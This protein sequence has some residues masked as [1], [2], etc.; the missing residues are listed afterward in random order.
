MSDPLQE[1]TIIGQQGYS[2]S[3]SFGTSYNTNEGMV[4]GW[5]CVIGGRTIGSV[6]ISFL[7]AVSLGTHPTNPTEA[8][9]LALVQFRE[10]HTEVVQ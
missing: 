3:L 9:R 10:R 5:R 6:T 8:A 4:V 7:N 1:L 2:V